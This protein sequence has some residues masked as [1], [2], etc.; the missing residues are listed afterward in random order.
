MK[1]LIIILACIITAYACSDNTS[2][3][4]SGEK[5]TSEGNQSGM[6]PEQEKGLQLVASEGCLLQCHHVSAKKIGPSYEAI[7]EKYTDEAMHRDSLVHRIIN[8]SVGRWGTI[9]MA[10]NVHVSEEDARTMVH[11]ILSLK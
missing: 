5:E 7:A 11:Y 4:T 8:G 6:T 3:K 2:G 9:P 10:A 1:K